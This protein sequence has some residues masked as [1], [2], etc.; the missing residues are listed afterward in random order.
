M[1][2]ELKALRARYGYTQKDLAK[3]I[4]V[5][6]TSYNKRENGKIQF[7]LKEIKIIKKEFR[8]SPADVDL[9]FF[10]DEVDFKSTNTA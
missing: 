5:D 2:R 3:V 6:E 9:I 8:L 4:G 7:T 1:L 10:N